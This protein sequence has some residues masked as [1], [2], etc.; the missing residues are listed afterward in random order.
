MMEDSHRYRLLKPLPLHTG[1]GYDGGAGGGGGEIYIPIFPSFRYIPFSLSFVP[2][3]FLFPYLVISL[4]IFLC[5]P[6]FASVQICLSLPIFFL[7]IHGASFSSS[8]S[9]TIFRPP[10]S[11]STPLQMCASL[12]ILIFST[13]L[14]LS[15]SI[16]VVFRLIYSIFLFVSSFISSQTCSALPILS[17]LSFQ[18]CFPSL[19]HFISLRVI[20]YSPL[21]FSLFIYFLPYSS[22]P[23]LPS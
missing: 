23:P 17:Y 16:F 2:D 11:I 14:V 8:P 21:Y 15:L 7:P 13:Y 3:V 12:P 22:L 6:L 5:I 19:S 18:M 1:N 9:H 4:S 10:I 20:L